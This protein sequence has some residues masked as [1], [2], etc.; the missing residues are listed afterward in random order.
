MLMPSTNCHRGVH[1][2]PEHLVKVAKALSCHDS[3]ELN[4]RFRRII[5]GSGKQRCQRSGVF[6]AVVSCKRDQQRVLCG[7]V[8]IDCP[9]CDISMLSDFLDTRLIKPLRLE[10]HRSG[11]KNF[12]S[13]SQALAFSSALKVHNLAQNLCP[14]LSALTFSRSRPSDEGCA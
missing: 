10:S 6:G 13:R 12:Q 11:L 3:I 2:S 4:E 1:M 5:R 14:I 7:K 8:V 9:R